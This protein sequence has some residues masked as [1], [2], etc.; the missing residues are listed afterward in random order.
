MGPVGATTARRGP[1]RYAHQ[2][3]Q[4]GGVA[5]RRQ[6]FQSLPHGATPIPQRGTV[7]G[8]P[9]ERSLPAV[10]RTDWPRI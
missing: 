6:I 5:C 10:H 7:E 2:D 9:G 3:R 8:C 4:N 1:L